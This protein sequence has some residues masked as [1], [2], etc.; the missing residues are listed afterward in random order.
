[1]QTFT[2]KEYLQIDIANNY[3]LDKL[4]WEERL[5]W[6]RN[7]ATNLDTLINDA[8]N[9][10]LFYAGVSAWKESQAGKPI[11]Y[12]ISLD[13]TSSGL[14]I[15][16]V[17]TGDHQAAK[18]CNVVNVGKRQ[19]AYNTIF[20]LMLKEVKNKQTIN[21]NEVKRAIMTSLYG[22][23]KVPKD[24]FGEGELLSIF[25]N[26]L[27]KSAPLVWD[28]NKAFLEIWD[29]TAYKYSWVLPDNFHV[30]TKVMTTAQETINFYDAQHFV[31][32]QVNKPEENGRS[33]GA[34]VTHS[35]DGMIVREITRRCDY[36]PKKI[37]ALINLIISNYSTKEDDKAPLVRSLWNHYEKT[38]YLSARILDVLNENN[39]H[40]VDSSV[41]LELI[42]TLPSRPFKVIST[43]DC[44][45]VHPNYGNELRQQ[46][47]Q[48]LYL[49]AKSNL[50]ENLLTQITGHP[51]T[52]DK[53]KSFA[54]EILVT[55]YALS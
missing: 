46:Y 9:P 54:E 43:H 10:A 51:I 18:L 20:E 19:D 6:F 30:H 5:E 49:I 48:Q 1:M 24:V 29:P 53:N 3:G 17:L 55:N 4:S 23:E 52:F 2:P 47:N 31:Y 28:L 36:D 50:L 8:E 25:H 45:R 33:L 34:N 38:G 44:F 12:P 14:Q 7:N 35:I 41:I 37:D 11:G 32:R 39:I 26:V 13:A 40:L 22:S 27:N 42:S 15:L 16:S 21:R